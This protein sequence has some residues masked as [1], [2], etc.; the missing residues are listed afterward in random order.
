MIAYPKVLLEAIKIEPLAASWKEKFLISTDT[1]EKIQTTYK[2]NLYTPSIFIRIALFVFTCIITSAFLGF[3][4]LISQGGGSDTAIGIR[5]CI[6]GL[7]VLAALEFTIREKKAYRAGIDDALLYIGLSLL[8]IGLCFL[9]LKLANTENEILICLTLLPFLILASIRYSDRLLAALAFC[10]LFGLV[11]FSLQSGENN[12]Q[13][14]LPFAGILLSAIIYYS[15]KK[16]FTHNYLAWW[17]SLIILEILSLFT[18]YLSGNYLIVRELSVELMNLEIEKG[19]DIPLA[20]IFY[21]FTI[22]IPLLYL[23]MGIKNK[24]RV[25]LRCGLIILALA[26]LTFKY[27]YSLGHH[28]ISLTIAGICMITISYLLMT[29]L[30]KSTSGFTSKNDDTVLNNDLESVVIAQTFSGKKDEQGFEFGGGKSGGGGA[31]GN[32]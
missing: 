15:N 18:F 1:S 11:F 16:L 28:E 19:A 22:L 27:Y 29:Y 8:M 12:L 32:F 17:D 4:T 23:Y 2:N 26:V 10:C 3:A 14:L 6:Y 30:K 5:C 20:F 7:M 21:I 25:M 24:D 13:S 9:I 31:G